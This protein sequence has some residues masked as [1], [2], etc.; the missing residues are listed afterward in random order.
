M[1]HSLSQ[2]RQGCT[3]PDTEVRRQRFL[4]DLK[5]AAG[6]QPVT[7]HRIRWVFT[8]NTATSTIYRFWRWVPWMG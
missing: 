3:D 2:C 8:T 6:P 5:R 7:V 4:D 1:C